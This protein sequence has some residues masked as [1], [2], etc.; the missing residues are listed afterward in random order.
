MDKQVR[1]VLTGGP[2]FGKTTIISALEAAG[3][4]VRHEVARDVIRELRQ[5]NLD[6]KNSEGLSRFSE[7]VLKARINQY[8]E[9]EPGVTFYDRGLPDVAGFLNKPWSGTP[10]HLRSACIKH[11]YHPKVFVTPPWPEIFTSDNERLES[12]TEALRVHENLIHC[13]DALGYELIEV[14]LAPVK[15]RVQFI[16]DT[17]SE[18]YAL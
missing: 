3:H 4:Q 10:V 13:Y 1:I 15:A 5:L 8:T 11:P 6:L 2:G 7:E 9:A 16:L 17:V 18:W 12:L 14:P